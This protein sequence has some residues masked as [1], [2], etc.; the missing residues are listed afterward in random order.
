M[1]GVWLRISVI[2]WRSS[3]RSAM[4]MRGISGKWNAIWHS[5]ES[6]KVADAVVVAVEER[7]DVH[8]IDDRVLEPQRIVF[9]RDGRRYD[10]LERHRQVRCFKRHASP[11]A[12]E[13]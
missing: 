2:G 11:L 6:L 12:S 7:L 9:D 4:N 5:S 10:R 3:C 8:L 1:S 13:C